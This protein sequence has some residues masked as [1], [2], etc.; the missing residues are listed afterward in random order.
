MKYNLIINRKGGLLGIMDKLA[1]ISKAAGNSFAIWVL[2]FAVL[3][4]IFPDAFK[5]IALLHIHFTWNN[6]VWDGT[7]SLV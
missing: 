5:W 1:K 2:L 4:M 3:A 6:N 7:H